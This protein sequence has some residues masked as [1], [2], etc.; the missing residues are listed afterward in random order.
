MEE[1]ASSA[2]GTYRNSMMSKIRSYRRDF[3]KLR[4]DL[5]RSEVFAQDLESLSGIR[6][7]EKCNYSDFKRGQEG[8]ANLQTSFSFIKNC[9]LQITCMSSEQS[10]RLRLQSNFFTTA[11]LG[12]EIDKTMAVS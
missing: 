6:N 4:K 1:E 2:P 5:V 11:Y 9:Y 8:K 3:D 7:K 10:T 12:A